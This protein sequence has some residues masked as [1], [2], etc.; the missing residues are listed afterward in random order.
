[1]DTFN[2]QLR[3]SVQGLTTSFLRCDAVLPSF[4][5]DR[6]FQKNCML[7]KAF[8][9]WLI[10]FCEVIDKKLPREL[11]DMIYGQILDKD[12]IIRVYEADSR[13][14]KY[15]QHTIC[16]LPSTIRPPLT[17]D[18][19]SLFSTAVT[20]DSFS[21]ELTQ[22]FYMRI[23]IQV[24]EPSLLP[25]VM[26]N[27]VFGAAALAGFSCNLHINVYGDTST[28]DPTLSAQVQFLDHLRKIPPSQRVH[29]HLFFSDFGTDHRALQE[30]K[31]VLEGLRALLYDMKA[32]NTFI[33]LT[34][35][36]K[37][38]GCISRGFRE[39]RWPV[40]ESYTDSTWLLEHSMEDFKHVVDKADSIDQLTRDE[41]KTKEE[42]RARWDR[43]NF[44]YMRD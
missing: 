26:D 30:Y 24:T 17:A 16:N 44:Y 15:C 31:Y 34:K 7:I 19:E 40:C 23:T 21:R 32:Q 29:I 37:G 2:Y 20:G 42:V 18:V 1:M 22:T 13:Y 6:A 28:T 36:G 4:S 14:K 3:D 27:K 5:K 38:H 9:K 12:Y 10:E 33:K 39:C 43:L 11:R 25:A 8:E 35:R 41:A